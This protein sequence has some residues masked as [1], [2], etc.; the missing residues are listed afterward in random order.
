MYILRRK[1]ELKQ[2]GTQIYLRWG[3]FVEHVGGNGDEVSGG[4]RRG[5]LR[6]RADAAMDHRLRLCLLRLLRS[7][8][9]TRGLN[10]GAGLPLRLRS[11][12]W[13]GGDGRKRSGGRRREQVRTC[14][15]PL[16]RDI[17]GRRRRLDG[18]FHRSYHGRRRGK[19]RGGGCG[20]RGRVEAHLAQIWRQRCR[21][22]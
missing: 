11:Y 19:Q 10:L 2:L 9:R 4:G 20:R 13:R 3:Q 15:L 18:S 8:P 5:G 21:R 12:R 22:R 17:G 7:G 1:K 6:R 14:A 16:L